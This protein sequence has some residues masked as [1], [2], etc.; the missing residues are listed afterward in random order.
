MINQ[1]VRR[2]L[3]EVGQLIDAADAG[4]AA[5]LRLEH[6]RGHDGARKA[7]LL[8]LLEPHGR[9]RDRAHGPG[10]AHFAE[11]GA[12]GGQRQVEAR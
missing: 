5:G 4:E 3:D 2:F 9:V 10:E 7:E 12:V 11:I 6:A 1:A 8:R